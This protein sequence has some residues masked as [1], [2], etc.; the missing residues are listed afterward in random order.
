[1]AGAHNVHNDRRRHR[2]HIGFANPQRLIL[3]RRGATHDPTPAH[4][5]SANR[6]RLA[7]GIATLM[8][9]R[10]RYTPSAVI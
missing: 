1:M 9:W 6:E 3:V 4:P 5:T 10:K 2:R 7:P 8:P